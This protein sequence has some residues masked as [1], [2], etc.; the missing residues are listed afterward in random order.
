[1]YYGCLGDFLRNNNSKGKGGEGVE[2]R[3]DEVRVCEVRFCL[4]GWFGYLVI[5]L[6]MIGWVCCLG[7]FVF[8]C[9]FFF[10]VVWIGVLFLDGCYG[11]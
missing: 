1:M 3:E 5:W 8:V 2:M 11:D 6:L 9:W 7:S 4:I 10:W